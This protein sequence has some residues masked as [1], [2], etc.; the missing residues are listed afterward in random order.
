MKKDISIL[1]VHYNTPGLLRQTLKGL[2]HSNPKVTF[3]VIVVDNNPSVR[4]R[5]WVQKEFTLATV[6]MSYDNVG[7]GPGM[8]LAMQHAN[9]RYY[10]VFNPDIAAFAGTLDALV[11]YMDEHPDIGI[12]GPKLLNPDRTLQHSCY[13]FMNPSVILY[14]RIPILR[15][16]SFAKRAVDAYQMKDWAHE[17]AADVDYLLGAAMFTRKEAIDQVGGFDPYFFMYFEDQ[18]WCR[19]FWMAGWRVVY[20]PDI[21]F[22]HYHRR[23]TAEG[24]FFQ[25]I[26]NPLTR[27]Q[28]ESAIYYYRKYRGVSNP[29][30]DH[31]HVARSRVSSST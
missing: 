21:F 1:I 24:S 25:Q 12:L 26:H 18:D 16:L 13:R 30:F 17:E 3:E 7:F 27:I 11:D 6:I 23:E 20:H 31:S 10:F 9:A 4:V 5:D 15:S 29:R 2:Y 14:R 8:N 19:R 22:I 28:M